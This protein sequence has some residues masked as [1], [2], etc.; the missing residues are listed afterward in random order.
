MTKSILEQF[1]YK[2]LVAHNGREAIDIFHEHKDEIYAAIVDMM[3]PVMGGK[4]TIKELKKERPD[5]KVISISGYQEGHEPFGIKDLDVDAFLPK[6][7]NAERLLQ[8]LNEV[9]H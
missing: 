3:M 5:L 9:K 8:T 6:P 2:V 1:E 4:P 7:F